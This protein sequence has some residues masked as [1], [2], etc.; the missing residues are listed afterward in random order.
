MSEL[1]ND[2]SRTR[3]LMFKLTGLAVCEYLKCDSPVIGGDFK[4]LKVVRLNETI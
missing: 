1:A 4:Y 2:I 3:G